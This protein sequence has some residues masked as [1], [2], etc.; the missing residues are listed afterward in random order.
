[1]GTRDPAA[2]E[3]RTVI[4]RSTMVVVRTFLTAFL[5]LEIEHPNLEMK[6]A[7]KMTSIHCRLI[8]VKKRPWSQGSHRKVPQNILIKQLWNNIRIE[9]T[10]RKQF[11]R[12]S[13]ANQTS[14]PVLGSALKNNQCYHIRWG[15]IKAAIITIGRFV[16]IF[17]D[18]SSRASP[19]VGQICY[20]CRL[21]EQL[22]S[23]AVLADTA[24]LVRLM[25]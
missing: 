11:C 25:L 1:M 19:K 2:R 21:S 24:S 16:V 23:L 7:I 9:V 4:Q 20:S 17:M 14:T 15:S 18:P 22:A 5:Q 10:T 13:K 6:H 8:L 12:G 3:K